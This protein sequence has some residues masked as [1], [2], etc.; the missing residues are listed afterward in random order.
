M[1]YL[2]IAFGLSVV[3]GQALYHSV[4]FHVHVID[5]LSV[6]FFIL[7]LQVLMAVLI[8]EMTGF[9]LRPIALC[10]AGIVIGSWA[11]LLW[12]AVLTLFSI[13]GFAP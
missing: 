1:T 7:V 5:T 8:L 3:L 13:N 6:Y 10:L 2:W 12:L 9:R 11:G 4:A